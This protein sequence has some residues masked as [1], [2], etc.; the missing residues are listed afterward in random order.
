MTGM[1]V[2]L[3]CRHV[4]LVPSIFFP[5]VSLDRSFSVLSNTQPLKKQLFVVLIFSIV[6]LFSVID[7]PALVF[8]ISFLCVLWDYFA[9][10]F[11]GSAGGSLDIDLR[12]FL[13]K[14]GRGTEDG[15]RSPGSPYSLYIRSHSQSV[16]ELE[17]RPKP[18]VLSTP[19]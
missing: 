15:G 2:F 6:F 10:L 9:L 18:K 1:A 11:L 16:L 14:E 7:F 4:V 8:I 19:S 13:S 5:F 12:L 17:L 3:L